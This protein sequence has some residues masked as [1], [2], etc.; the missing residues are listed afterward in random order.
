MGILHLLSH[1][2][3]QR[4]LPVWKDHTNWFASTI[5]EE[6]RNIPSFLPTTH[7][8]KAF[9]IQYEEPSVQYSVY[10]HI[11]VLESS[12]RRLFSFIPRKVLEAKSLACDPLPPLTSLSQYDQEFFASVEDAFSSRL[13]TRRQR[14]NDERRLAQLIP[15]A[16]FR[17]QLQVNFSISF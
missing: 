13:R 10:R 16:A 2:Y 4:S 11:M 5:T 7:K 8:H 6:F 3:V 12:Y 9:L 15:D 17:Q 1:L 14:L